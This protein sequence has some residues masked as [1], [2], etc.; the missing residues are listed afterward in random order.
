MIKSVWHRLLGELVQAWC[1]QT[2]VHL[3]IKAASSVDTV[4]ISIS[5]MGSLK[6]Q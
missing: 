3:I 2:L 5:Q 6:A 4:V 1:R